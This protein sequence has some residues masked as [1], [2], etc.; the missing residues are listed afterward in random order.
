RRPPG[1]AGSATPRQAR[2]PALY[3]HARPARRGPTPTP[4]PAA[5][6]GDSLLGGNTDHASTWC[7]SCRERVIV[8]AHLTKRSI[9][10]IL[11]LIER[12]VKR[13][14]AVR[15]SARREP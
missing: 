6:A 3:G 15:K 11:A 7:V 10:T 8:Q 1:Q 12:L 13:A 14:M 5:S 2:C 4:A 9:E